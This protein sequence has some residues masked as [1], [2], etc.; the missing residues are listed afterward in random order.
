MNAP[1]PCDASKNDENVPTTDRAFGVAD[2]VEREHEQRR[3]HQRHPGA[4][5]AVPATRPMTV[6]QAAMTPMPIAASA[7]AIAPASRPP[8][9]SGTRAPTTLTTRIKIP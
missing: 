9:R 6:G 2:A 8:S 5:T 3:I 7:S 4:N 1:S